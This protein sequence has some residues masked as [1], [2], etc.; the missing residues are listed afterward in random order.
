MKQVD[1]DER[2]RYITTQEILVPYHRFAKYQIL[3]SINIEKSVLTYWGSVDAILL[4]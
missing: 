2:H 4:L 1:T 3:E